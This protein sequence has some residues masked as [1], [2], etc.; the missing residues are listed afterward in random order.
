VISIVVW[1]QEFYESTC[2]RNPHT[3]S[4][5]DLPERHILGFMPGDLKIASLSAFHNI[6]FCQHYLLIR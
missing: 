4:H 3:S 1:C 5:V 2:K 6:C